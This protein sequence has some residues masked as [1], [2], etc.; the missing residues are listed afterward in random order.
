MTEKAP[1]SEGGR[2][3]GKN[4]SEDR[5]LQKR[6]FAGPPEDGRYAGVAAVA[7]LMVAG[8]LTDWPS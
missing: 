7:E 8:M 6:E 3:K 2:Y 1:A 5:P 4:R